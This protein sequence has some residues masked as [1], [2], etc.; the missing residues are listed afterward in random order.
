ME[1]GTPTAIAIPGVRGVFI[2]VLATGMRASFEPISQVFLVDRQRFSEYLAA[3]SNK[4][5]YQHNRA[6]SPPCV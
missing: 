3:V 2:E 5:S 4:S 1:S 6:D